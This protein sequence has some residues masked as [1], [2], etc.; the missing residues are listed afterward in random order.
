MIFIV[1]QQSRQ[2]SGNVCG[3]GGSIRASACREL[4]IS[5]VTLPQPQW[6]QMW[7][8]LQMSGKGRKMITGL[9]NAANSV[10]RSHLLQ[11]LH[12]YTAL[13]SDSEIDACGWCACRVRHLEQCRER[14][15]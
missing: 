3:S 15:R 11:P 13:H 8:R 14:K 9:E 10:W 12:T 6:S 4:S 2:A 1:K 7:A 5:G